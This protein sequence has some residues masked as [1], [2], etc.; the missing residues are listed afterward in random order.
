MMEKEV[1]LNFESFGTRLARER[2]SKDLSQDELADLYSS[3]FEY[4]DSFRLNEIEQDRIDPRTIFDTVSRLASIMAIPQDDVVQL[5]ERYDEAR[6]LHE[7]QE[8]TI[9]SSMMAYR[10]ATSR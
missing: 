5:V 4:L 9:S 2:K 3:R 7:R 1:D 6:S 8:R 10:R